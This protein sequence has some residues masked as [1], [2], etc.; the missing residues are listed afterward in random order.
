MEA[1]ERAV[2]VAAIE[3]KAKAERVNER[4]T[5][6]AQLRAEAEALYHRFPAVPAGPLFPAA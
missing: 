3:F 5:T 4:F 2:E 6:L 1:D